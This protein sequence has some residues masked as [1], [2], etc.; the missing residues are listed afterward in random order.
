MSYLF[1]LKV[2]RLVCF[3]REIR[4]FYRHFINRNENKFWGLIIGLHCG[5]VWMA[6]LWISFSLWVND[7]QGWYYT[8]C[9][10]IESGLCMVKSIY[11]IFQACFTIGYGDLPPP[12][13]TEKLFMCVYMVTGVVVF[14]YFLAV[15]SNFFEERFNTPD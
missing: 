6:S 5:V 15:F 4:S 1:Y 13:L 3:R 8:Y 9:S 2:F 12:V 10:N 11:L 14:S 7:P